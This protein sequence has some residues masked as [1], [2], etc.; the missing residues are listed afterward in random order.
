MEKSHDPA[1]AGRHIDTLLDRYP[2]LA[3]MRAELERAAA[4]LIQAV[5]Q[6][7]RILTAGNGGSFADAEHIT[8]ELLKGFCK[9]RP[10]PE[11]ALAEFGRRWGSEGT[12]LA[13]QLQ[14]GIPAINLSLAP[15]LTTA[16][17]NDV[18]PALAVA[19]N[20]WASGCPGDVLIAI[21][22][23]GNAANIRLALMAARVRGVGSILLTGA[24]HGVCERYADC[25]LAAPD[26]ETYRI[27]ELHLPIYHALC[28]AVEE[29]FFDE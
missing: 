23:G 5:A 21:S 22:T 16:F 1:A 29:A 25:V 13:R 20:L 2:A 14:M 17:G 4:M 19:Q 6:G 10:L 11:A 28:L 24:K 27:Q 8:G 9:K 3:G 15:A 7:G 12:E 26:C 18:D